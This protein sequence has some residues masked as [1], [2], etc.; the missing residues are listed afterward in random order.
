MIAAREGGGDPRFNL[1]L[2][3]AI[4]KAR[5][6]N[7]SNDAIDKAVKK[8]TGELGDQMFE[9]L[10]YE[11]YGPGGVAIVV[12]TLSDNRNRTAPELRRIFEVKGGKLGAPNSALRFFERKGLIAI[13]KDKATEEGVFEMATEAGAEDVTTGEDAFHVT[14]TPQEFVHVKKAFLDKGLELAQAELGFVATSTIQVDGKDAPKIEGLIEALEDHDDVQA[15]H[16]N[17]GGPNA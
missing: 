7:M 6:G 5:A 16:S 14:T 13:A 17:Y 8:A 4:D 1:K 15:V 2:S 3:Y 11:G 10:T 12:E 9:E